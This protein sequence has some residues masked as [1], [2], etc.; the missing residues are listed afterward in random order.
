LIVEK[1]ILAQSRAEEIKQ[2]LANM[3]MVR[4]VFEQ[5]EEA[6]DACADVRWRTIEEFKVMSKAQG[7]DNNTDTDIPGVDL[8]CIRARSSHRTRT[9]KCSTHC[10][11]IRSPIG[12]P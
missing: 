4:A 12:H 5:L 10:N 3:K 9:R 11:R 7:K 6:K 2:S 1:R 8:I